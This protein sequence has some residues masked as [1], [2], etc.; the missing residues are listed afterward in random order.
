MAGSKGAGRRW[1]WVAAALVLPLWLGAC[2]DPGGIPRGA[3]PEPG[4]T[5]G[6][7]AAVP[8]PAV[9]ASEPQGP[10]P[11]GTASTGPADPATAPPAGT[12]VPRQPEEVTAPEASTSPAG[13]S[14]PS[15]GSQPAA[16]SG[17]PSP[18]GTATSS[19]TP[20]TAPPLGTVTVYYVLLDDGGSNGVRFG[21][22][23]SLVGMRV[24]NRCRRR[25]THSWP[26]PLTAAPHHRRVKPGRRCTTR[27]QPPG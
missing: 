17:K 19:S 4:G 21:C 18:A 16:R 27:W 22:N 15:T 10:P 12:A 7:P 8:G 24:S 3:P 2:D 14:A 13:S 23:D 11:P 20:A 25:S 5:G 6:N 1:T 26:G 9:P